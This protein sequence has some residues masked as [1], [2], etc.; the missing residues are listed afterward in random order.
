MEAAERNVKN[1]PQDIELT[2]KKGKPKTSQN[3]IYNNAQA[4]AREDL[5]EIKNMPNKQKNN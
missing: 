3:P 5:N 4:N 2:K 1:N